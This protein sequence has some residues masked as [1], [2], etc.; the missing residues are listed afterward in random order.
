MNPILMDVPAPLDSGNLV[1]LRIPRHGLSTREADRIGAMLQAFVTTPSCRT[2]WHRMSY[3][4]SRGHWRCH[5]RHRE[6]A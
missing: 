5:S 3:D 1:W 6:T 2:C 4:Q